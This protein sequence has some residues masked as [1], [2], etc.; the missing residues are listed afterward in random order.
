MSPAPLHIATPPASRDDRAAFKKHT[1]RKR[2]LLDAAESGRE[3]S[4]YGDD[5]FRRGAW[6]I[7]AF[8]LVMLGIGCWLILAGLI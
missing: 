8:M 2:S 7:T 3:D 1:S 6:L 5:E 4:A